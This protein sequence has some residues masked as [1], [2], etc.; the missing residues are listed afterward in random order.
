MRRS[1]AAAAGAVLPDSAA[2][3]AMVLV[4]AL[5]LAKAAVLALFVTPLWD[6]PDEVGHYAVIADLADGKG[7]PLPGRS[8]LPP[9]IVADWAGGKP[10]STEE[11]WNW[12]AQHPPLYHLTAVPFLAAGRALTSDPHRRYRSPR[13]LS[14]LSGAAALLVL[15][16]VFREASGDAVFALSAASAVSFLPMFTHMSS[17]TN[18]DVFLAFLCGIAAL[19]WVRLAR[20]GRYSDGVK[21]SLALAAAGFTKLSALVV[22]AALLALSWRSLASRAGRRTIEWLSMA[23]LSV[24]LPALWALRH[25]LLL[26]NTR[27]HPVSKEPFDP[28]SFLSY[29]RNDPVV[30]HTFKNFVGLIGWTARG[31]GRVEWFQISGAYFSVYFT[32]ALAA[33]AG[34]AVWFWRTDRSPGRLAG[35]IAAVLVFSFCALW[36]FSRADGS[37]PFK[38]LFYSLLAAVPFLALS[39]LFSS[40]IDPDEILPAASQAVFLLFAAAYLVNSWEAYEIYGAMRA[41]NGRYFF[42]VLPWM[43]LAFALPAARLMRP[44]RRRGA[45][46]LAL[47]AAMFVDET[48]FFLV[49][50]IP[51]DRRAP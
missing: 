41:T 19:F 32:I 25:V 1:D 8:V 34:A 51:F 21:M 29:L 30:D 17:G 44:G 50:V 14:A 38:R 3:R 28:G 20:R 26:G 22:A 49:R 11:R 46:L 9:D 36:L 27:L 7:L 33:A 37:E 47:P 48:L 31:A 23:A 39:R 4:A 24:S 43:G 35:R 2:R 13:L 42:A 12:V 45:L 10:L 16:A 15:F 18:H 5:F 40:R 6:V